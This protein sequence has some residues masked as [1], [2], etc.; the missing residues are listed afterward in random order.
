MNADRREAILNYIKEH[1]HASLRELTEMW[2]GLSEMTLR[3]DM[4]YLEEKGHIIRTRGGAVAANLTAMVSEDVYSRRAALNISEKQLIAHKA[5]DLIKERCSIFLDSG[6]TMMCFARALPDA[7]YYIVTADPN[8][9]LEVIRRQH[10]S[11]TLIG[12]NLSRNT[13]SAS[14]ASSMEFLR[15]LNVDLAF[16]SCSGFALDTGFTSG[17]FS[18]CEIKRAVLEKARQRVMLMDSSKTDKRMPF[19][20][21][22]LNELDYLI[23]ENLPEALAKEAKDCGVKVL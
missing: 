22:R 10:T 23:T 2:S 11:V 16:M 12:G 9:A 19:S 18:E 7:G 8:I 20:F 21:A 3:R 15:D 17:T 4:A 6:S 13:L 5:L 1:G 14:G